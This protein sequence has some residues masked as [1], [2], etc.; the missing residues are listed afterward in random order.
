MKSILTRTDYE[1]YLVYLY[2]GADPDPLM[3]CLNRAYLDFNRTL[4]GMG[5]LD[6]REALFA[7]ARAALGQA[8]CSLQGG[9]GIADQDAFDAWH[10]ATCK[11]LA[12]TCRAHRYDSFYVGQA[13]KWINMTL[14]YVF[15]MGEERLPGFTAVYPFCHVP[16]DNFLLQHL[17]PYGLKALPCAWSRLDDYE[18]YLSC[19]RWIRDS[20]SLLPL[21]TEFLVWM[22][23]PLPQRGT[24]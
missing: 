14:K 1:D 9:A 5:S 24:V 22:G 18:C 8:I 7:A 23:K 21:D 19:Q 11:S 20:F 2:F 6:S 16:L 3:L 17:A 13:Q 15:T 4:H 10:H 12:D